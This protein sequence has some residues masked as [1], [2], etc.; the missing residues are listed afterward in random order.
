MACPR[1]HGRGLGIAK[2][3]FAPL[4]SSARARASGL[5]V[6]QAGGADGFLGRRRDGGDL[7][8]ALGF[9]AVDAEFSGGGVDAGGRA[10]ALGFQLNLS[11]NSRS[12]SLRL[13]ERDPL[14]DLLRALQRRQLGP[15][16]VLSAIP[17]GSETVSMLTTE[18]AE[19]TGKQH[20]HVMRDA[21][22]MLTEL[23]EDAPKFGGIY[24]DAYGRDKPCYRLPKRHV[25]ILLTGYSVTLRAAV[26]DR[27][28]QLEAERQ[29]TNV[30]A[31]PS[32]WSIEGL[33]EVARKASVPPIRGSWPG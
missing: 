2:A 27:V 32:R 14:G 3:Q 33:V 24:Q 13:H 1:A 9:V 16:Q 20:G 4:G 8:G 19:R 15:V 22:K 17:G 11:R 18:I 6:V 10:T 28:K 30:V 29:N 23:G 7:G 12:L 21:A 25:M 5:V 26:L 31:L